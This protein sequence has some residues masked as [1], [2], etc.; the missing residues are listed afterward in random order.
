MAM[1]GVLLCSALTYADSENPLGRPGLVVLYSADTGKDTATEPNFVTEV[2]LAIDQYEVIPVRLEDGDF[3]TW[4]FEMQQDKLRGLNREYRAIYSIWVTY[5]P[6][7]IATLFLCT[8]LPQRA[9]LRTVDVP[10]GPDAEKEL[11][12]A[13]RELLDEMSLTVSPPPASRPK[14]DEEPTFDTYF[15]LVF[16]ARGTFGLV[17]QEGPSVLPGAGI[18]CTLLITPAN[19]INFACWMSI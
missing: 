18:T 8:L 11:A 7:G 13:A 14:Q 9:F 12:V 6:S 2:A 17:G 16:S 15:D 3:K 10:S 4:S 19:P 5:A 1:G